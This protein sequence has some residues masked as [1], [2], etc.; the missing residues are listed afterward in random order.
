MYQI[1]QSYSLITLTVYAVICLLGFSMVG[2]WSWLKWHTATIEEVIPHQAIVVVQVPAIGDTKEQVAATISGQR[3][4]AIPEMQRLYQQLQAL[5]SLSQQPDSVTYISKAIRESLYQQP[6]WFSLHRTSKERLDWLSYT[7]LPAFFEGDSIQAALLRASVSSLK[8]QQEGYWRKRIYRKMVLHEWVDSLH[9]SVIYCVS[10]YKNIGIGSTSPTLVEDAIRTGSE[11]AEE[12]IKAL[13][14]RFEPS[15]KIQLYWNGFQAD[16]LLETLTEQQAS[17]GWPYGWMGTLNFSGQQVQVEATPFSPHGLEEWEGRW[18]TGSRSTI[19]PLIPEQTAWV[20]RY[21]IED[22]DDWWEQQAPPHAAVEKEEQ[23][24]Q[25]LNC[26]SD[27]YALLQLPEYQGERRQI[28]LIKADSAKFLEWTEQLPTVGILPKNHPIGKIIG[29]K[30]PVSFTYEKGYIAFASNQ[31]LLA[32]WRSDIQEANTWINPPLSHKKSSI[33]VAWNSLQAW[34]WLLEQANSSWREWFERQQLFLTQLRTGAIALDQEEGMLMVGWMA[35]MN[36]LEEIEDG[37]MLQPILQ[38]KL[39]AKGKLAP[40][41]LRLEGKPLEEAQVFFQD[42]WNNVKQVG[43]DGKVVWS[44]HTG[45]ALKQPLEVFRGIEG[46]NSGIAFTAKNKLLMR[47]IKGKPMYGGRRFL[48][49]TP[50][51]YTLA[52]TAT[53][54]TI[55]AIDDPLGN[56]YLYDLKGRV[57]YPW[58]PLRHNAPLIQPLEVVNAAGE[59]IILALQ[60]DAL[61]AHNLEGK[62][63]EGFPLTFSDLYIKDWEVEKGN[64]L[65]NT[66][67]WLLASR[68]RISQVNLKGNIAQTL[69]LPASSLEDRFYILRSHHTGSQRWYWLRKEPQSEGKEKYYIYTHLGEE[70]MS[71]TVPT[72][73]GKLQYFDFGGGLEFLSVSWEQR[74]ESQVFFFNGEPCAEPFASEAQI[75]MQYDS[76][77]QDLII[78]RFKGKTLQVNRLDL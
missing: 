76:K 5:D 77:K 62:A 64:I 74:K 31:Q 36:T 58:R 65:D 71:M 32:A 45:S 1:K 55:I 44:I 63:L 12:Q 42:S 48:P 57:I 53:G 54:K 69:Q 40:Q 14:V 73:G 6:W 70:V 68:G 24:V 59:T 46:R 47:N 52:Q 28:M 17:E 11:V 4:M 8:K 33:Y 61:R 9:N 19:W 13:P 26:I 16:E 7:Q 25:F 66:Y 23:A 29:R 78:Y 37:S 38:V 22:G 27:E 3:L 50:A 49:F 75:A 34:P 41:T 39:P 10:K 35:P 2:Y 43:P 15:E 30:E 21:A 18:A 72:Q 51:H 67:I 20:V 56:A 60:E